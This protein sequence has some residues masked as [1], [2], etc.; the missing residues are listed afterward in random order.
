MRND[1]KKERK[2]KEE[3]EKETNRYSF[4]RKINRKHVYVYSM[5]RESREKKGKKYKIE[6]NKDS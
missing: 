1:K 2:K 6:R 3:E 5:K 4:S